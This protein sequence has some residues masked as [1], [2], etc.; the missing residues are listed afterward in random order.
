[1]LGGA[2]IPNL[3]HGTPSVNPEASRRFTGVARLYGDTAYAAFRGAHVA[4]VGVGGVGSW[5]AE[6]LAR[7]G[8]GTLTLIDLDHVAESNINRQL[9]ALES[10]LGMSKVL[11]MQ[12]RI[13]DI[14]QAT[15]VNVVDDFITAENASGLIAPNVNIIIDAC[16]QT[17]AKVALA[18]LARDRGISCIMS[19]AAGGKQQPQAIEVSDIAL[20]THDRLLASVRQRLRKEH[21]FP[22][23]GAMGVVCVFSREQVKTTGVADAQ[24]G[25]AC[26][27][28]G[29]G[30]TVT[31][32]FGMCLAAQ[33]LQRL[34]TR[35]A[36]VAPA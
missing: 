3:A 2:E 1:M 26:A 7:S 29:S 16:D 31:A 6:A 20:T 21:A 32:T 19:G 34:A 23:S 15:K 13:A 14:D 18:A 33:A 22:S 36:L 30:V 27:G 12:A 9:H 25:L 35:H 5:A 11:A 4:V 28:F 8:I 17:R 24:A 10:T